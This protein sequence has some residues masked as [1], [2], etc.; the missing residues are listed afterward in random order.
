MN[1]AQAGSAEEKVDIA[2]SLS[3]LKEEEKKINNL[4]QKYDIRL[5]KFG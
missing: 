4:L 1:P 3:S 2:N 5:H